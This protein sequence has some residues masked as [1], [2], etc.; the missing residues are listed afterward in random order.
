[1][2]RF[3]DN[4]NQEGTAGEPIAYLGASI[5]HRIGA[6]PTPWRAV[7]AAGDR[8]AWRH[9]QRGARPARKVRQPHAGRASSRRRR[10]R[11]VDKPWIAVDIPRA[12]AQM[13]T[14][15]GPG[16]DVPLQTFP[17]GRVYMAYA[18]FDGPGEAARADHV[19]LARP[20]AARRGARR[21]S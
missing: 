17:G 4:N 18:L 3:I 1:M 10:R 19:Q 21:E 5:V 14:I 20:I 13:C 9:A 6:V 15:G 16:T 8:H 2:A 7:R 12:G 11:L